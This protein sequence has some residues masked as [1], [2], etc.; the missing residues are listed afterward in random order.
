MVDRAQQHESRHKPRTSLAVRSR[1][2]L[3]SK[4]LTASGPTSLDDRPPAAGPHPRTE[5]VPSLT[6]SVL[7]LIRPLHGIQA[8]KAVHR[9][10]AK[11]RVRAM[12]WLA[13]DHGRQRLIDSLGS[14]AS[15]RQLAVPV[16]TASSWDN[17]PSA[18]GVPATPCGIRAA[19]LIL[20]LPT[21]T[22]GCGSLPFPP[23]LGTGSFPACRH[24]MTSDDRACVCRCQARTTSPPKLPPPRPV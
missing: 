22:D 6:T 5:A 23:P 12:S 13:G 19:L 3:R 7:R 4:S 1:A 16:D 18:R 2:T 8:S 14:R 9:C 21:Q 20:A 15:Q 24:R 17:A 10:A 11:L